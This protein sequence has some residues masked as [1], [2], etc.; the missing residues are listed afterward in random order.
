MNEP[1]W[2]LPMNFSEEFE[3]DVYKGPR[4]VQRRFFLREL[5]KLRGR[6]LYRKSTLR[7]K[8]GTVVLFQCAGMIIAKAILKR[9]DASS[10]PREKRKGYRGA[11]LFYAHTIRIYDPPLES[12]IIRK[13]WGDKFTRFNQTKWI[14][15][16]QRYPAF[17]R[18]VARREATSGGA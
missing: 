7:A 3:D 18:E 1:V 5:R 17:Q 8:R 4:D 15:N 16:P 9:P 12:D 10:E 2:I 11:I 14:L 13:H 6:Y